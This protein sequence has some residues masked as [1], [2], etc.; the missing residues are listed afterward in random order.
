M[1]KFGSGKSRILTVGSGGA[2]ILAIGFATLAFSSKHQAPRASDGA[3]TVWVQRPDGSQQCSQDHTQS[4]E[5]GS[6]DLQSAKIQVLDSRKG[7]DGKMRMQMCGAPTGNQNKY[8][9]RR[10]DLPRAL[11]LGFQQ[12][13]DSTP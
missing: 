2:V 6:K 11:A 7:D 3:E 13:Q 5:Q 8:E 1:L 12:A 9:I 4:L 10:S